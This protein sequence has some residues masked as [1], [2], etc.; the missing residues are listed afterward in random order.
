MFYFT[1]SQQQLFSSL[2]FFHFNASKF[3]QFLVK[4]HFIRLITEFNRGCRRRHDFSVFKWEDSF[5]VRL[6][7]SLT[8]NGY[9]PNYKLIRSIV[10]LQRTMKS[11]IILAVCLT[12]VFA[13]MN[14]ILYEFDDFILYRNFN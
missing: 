5:T 1:R 11:F 2:S 12:T 13:G 7:L 8:F 14:L 6:S 4:N 10:K 9:I 3:Y